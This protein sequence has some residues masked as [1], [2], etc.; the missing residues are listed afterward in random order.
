LAVFSLSSC[1]SLENK[2][3]LTKAPQLI[4]NVV[5]SA[6]KIGVKKQPK[7]EPYLRALVTVIDTFALGEDLTPEALEQAIKTAKIDELETPEAN[8]VVVAVVALYKAYYGASVE[9]K[10]AEN[11]VLVEVLKSLSKSIVKGLDQAK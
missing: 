9:S 8:A 10:I 7:T 3:D 1:A 11:T 5:P 4:N 6:V 2:F